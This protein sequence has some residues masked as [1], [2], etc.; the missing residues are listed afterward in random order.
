[1]NWTTTS[2]DGSLTITLLQ[3][4]DAQL[5][6]FVS[7]ITNGEPDSVIRLSPLGLEISDHE[8]TNLQADGKAEKKSINNIVA[9]IHGKQNLS[10]DECNEQ[11]IRFTNANGNTLF[12]TL[13]AYNDG[14]AFRYGIESEKQTAYTVKK[15][16]TG[17][18]VPAGKAW[19]QP[20]DKI[21]MW[22]PA[23]EKPFQNGIPVGTTSP[24]EEGW[25]F[26]A[27]FETE[28]HWILIT[29]SDLDANYAG[30]HLQ[31]DA[32]GGLYTLRFP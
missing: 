24:H 17:F 22:T 6:Y 4:P 12:I 13:R 26:P 19:L 5:Q 29:E 28:K 25:C 7:R 14:V 31:P 8:L 9:R 1:M 11:K 20:Y 23:Y 30:S 32:P 3:T 10:H 18:S 15:E 21:T 27:L 16:F 2:P